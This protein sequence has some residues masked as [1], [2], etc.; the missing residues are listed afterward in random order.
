M[1]SPSRRVRAS[2]A[3][4]RVKTEPGLARNTVVV[5]ALLVIAAVVGGIILANQRFI[6]PWDNRQILYAAFADTPGISPANGQ[7]VRIAGVNV[8]D[9]VGAQVDAHGQAVLT[10]SIQ[11]GH[12]LYKNASLVL[13]PKSPLNEMYVEI[14]PGGPPADVIPAGYEYPISNTVRPVQPDEVLDH[15][16]DNA[17][18]AL[19]SLLS[20]SDV[21]LTNAKAN[22]PEGLDATR[23]VGDDLRPV[24]EQLAVR[25]ERIRTLITDLGEISK[26]VGGDDKRI[27]TLA[28]GLQTTLGSLGGHQQQ[29]DATLATLPG[30]VS[31][32]KRSTDAVQDLS[33][34]LDPTLRDLADASDEFPRALRRLSNTSDRID[35]VVDS[36]RPFIH[37]LRPVID[38]LRPF[39]DDLG[40]ALPQLHAATRELD[41]LTNALLPYLPD[42]G[43]F[44]I[45]SRSFT[46][47]ADAS[48]GIL[49]GMLM[50]SPKS[51]PSV[52]GPANG[53]KPIPAPALD[54]GTTGLQRLVPVLPGGVP[55]PPQDGSSAPRTHQSTPGGSRGN[56]K[57][58]L[59]A[60]G[61]DDAPR[62]RHSEQNKGSFSGLV[63]SLGQN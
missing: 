38:D 56:P 19:T 6:A 55:A 14:A 30:L 59:P 52:L 43:A 50:V 3:F 26:A 53:V 28:T 23:V 13:R 27:A 12:A 8:G 39:V 48:G 1:T 17:Q 2:R 46:S 31:N 16:D 9:I 7:E 36:A 22:L 25:K 5:I 44:A 54:N 29:L 57:R 24:A 49:R 41:P 61:G 35:D 45:N 47:T 51:L 15:L 20:E 33:G 62:A 37:E 34:Q 21:A 40:D 58:I 63:P 42:T 18:A 60:P 4:E 10:L 32:L 11:P